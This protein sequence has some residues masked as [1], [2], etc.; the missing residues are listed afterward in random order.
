MCRINYLQK[1]GNRIYKI[2]SKPVELKKNIL[3]RIIE[4]STPPYDV[5]QRLDRNIVAALLISCVG[6][7]KVGSGKLKRMSW[8]LFTVSSAVCL[9]I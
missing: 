8:N 3:D 9:F 7:E 2:G 5:S 4:W 1:N 6:I